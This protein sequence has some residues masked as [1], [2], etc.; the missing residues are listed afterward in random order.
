VRGINPT[1]LW[2]PVMSVLHG[3]GGVMGEHTLRQCHAHS[4]SSVIMPIN[5]VPEAMESLPP[6]RSLRLTAYRHYTT[7]L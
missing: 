1:G 6:R 7:R 5:G 3:G 4:R 2:A